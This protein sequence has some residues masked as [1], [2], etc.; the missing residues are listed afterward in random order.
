MP[1]LAILS[2]YFPIH[3]GRETKRGSNPQHPSACQIK[4]KAVLATVRLNF[5]NPDFF[6]CNGNKIMFWITIIIVQY[7]YY[8]DS[9]ISSLAIRSAAYSNVA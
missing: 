6:N 5:S 9:R 3:R 2:D 7:F 4:Y 1:C 8:A